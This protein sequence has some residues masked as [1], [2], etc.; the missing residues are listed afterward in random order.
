MIFILGYKERLFHVPTLTE[1]IDDKN[2][3]RVSYTRLKIIMDLA[4]I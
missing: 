3:L 1:Q 2:T 4:Q